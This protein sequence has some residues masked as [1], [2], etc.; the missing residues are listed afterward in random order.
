MNV[1]KLTRI[2]ES[3]IKFEASIPE[4][5][6]TNIGIGVENMHCKQPDESEKNVRSVYV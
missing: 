4:K 2:Y 5:W 6:K 1:F 3:L